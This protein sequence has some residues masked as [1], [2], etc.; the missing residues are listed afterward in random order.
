VSGAQSPEDTGFDH[1][2]RGTPVPPS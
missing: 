2:L 1:P